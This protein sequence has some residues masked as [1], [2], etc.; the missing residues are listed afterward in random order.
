[1]TLNLFQ[2]TYIPSTHV[3]SMTSS[4]GKTIFSSEVETKVRR[5]AL[6]IEYFS[7]MGNIAWKYHIQDKVNTS[8]CSL[9]LQYHVNSKS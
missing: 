9:Y 5:G 6:G 8:S 3:G 1:M 7:V 4:I 2:K